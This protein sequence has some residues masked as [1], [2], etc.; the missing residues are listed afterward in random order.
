MQVNIHE[1]KTQ[2]SKLIEAMQRGED[3]VIARSG[4]PV[5][6]LVPYDRPKF[7]FGIL[8]GKLDPS[9]IPDFLEPMDEEELRLW[10]GG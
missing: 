9:Q 5:A 7:R 1:A 6:K 2:L 10:E 8:K 3:V 4:V